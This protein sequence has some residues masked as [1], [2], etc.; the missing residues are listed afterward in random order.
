M[1]IEYAT[2]AA[3]AMCVMDWNRTCGSPIEC[4]RRW[5][6]RLG[7][8]V[9]EPS[10]DTSRVASGFGAGSSRRS[11][12]FRNCSPATLFARGGV[13]EWPKG[14]GCKP[15][16]SAY[17]GSN[18][19]S[20]TRSPARSASPPAAR[21]DP[22]R[23]TGVAPAASIGR[24]VTRNGGL[25]M[26]KRMTPGGLLVLATAV[27]VPVIAQARTAAPSTNATFLGA[28]K[29]SGKQATLRV[30]YACASGTALW[31]SAKQAASHGVDAKLK[32]EGS[33]KVAESW[34]ESH[35]NKFTCNGSPQTAPFA[36]DTAEK[37]SK[38][39]LVP[40]K[41]WVQ[42]CVT[43]GGEKLVLSKSGWVKVA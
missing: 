25:P 33:S 11:G 22:R 10:I 17:R 7:A 21:L 39:S 18:P 5:S 34:L 24:P 37:G 8:A 19:L 38:G 26:K 31:V 32:K 4:S 42:F 36:I 12:L 40:G 9:V 23:V 27:S 1:K 43:A 41:A 15:V 2:A 14:T 35:R 16:G 6:K 3:G 29:S 13:P 20:P 28:I 30:R